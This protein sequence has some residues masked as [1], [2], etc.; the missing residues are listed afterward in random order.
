MSIRV[1]LAG[2]ITSANIAAFLKFLDTLAA[3][4]I[5][6]MRICIIPSQLAVCSISKV[7]TYY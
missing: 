4:L 7:W 2:S 6:F 1:D 3:L 5:G